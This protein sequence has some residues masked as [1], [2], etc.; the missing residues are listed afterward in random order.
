MCALK[1]S[2]GIRRGQSGMG[3]GKVSGASAASSCQWQVDCGLDS[4]PRET[5][6]RIGI[7][8]D[9]GPRPPSLPP[10]LAPGQAGVHTLPARKSESSEERHV[11]QPSQAQVDL[12]PSSTVT[13]PT[14]R[15][16]RTNSS[17]TSVCV[18][19]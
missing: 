1:S 11:A 17:G 19:T 4:W 8:E 12:P 9:R 10:Q 18:C 7:R 6:R 2:R 5:R 14:G 3:W 15:W 13:L 16:E